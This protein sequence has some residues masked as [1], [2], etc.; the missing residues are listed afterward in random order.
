LKDLKESYPVEL[1]RHAWGNNI[2][3]EPAFAWWVSY[4]LNKEKRF[5]AKVKSKYSSRTHKYGIRIP[6]NI[7]EAKKIDKENGNTL[8]MDAIHLKINNVWVAFVECDENPEDLIGYKQI[9]GHLVFDVKLR[10]CFH[11]KSRFCADGHET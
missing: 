11:R 9:M 7:Q 5:F 2:H 8:W 4:T 3:D 6:R 10:E 1:A